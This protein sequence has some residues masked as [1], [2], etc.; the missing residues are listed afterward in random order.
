MACHACSYK[1]LVSQIRSIQRVVKGWNE[2]HS[3]EYIHAQV[4]H[5]LFLR[6][7]FESLIL[8]SAH[9]WICHHFLCICPRLELFNFHRF[10][11]CIFSVL[12]WKENIKPFCRMGIKVN[13]FQNQK[14]KIGYSG[15]WWH[16]FINIVTMWV[17]HQ[18]YLCSP[19]R[20]QNHFPYEWATIKHFTVVALLW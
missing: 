15:I 5:D 10:W 11:M 18:H 6:E 16:F 20:Q 3:M 9:N 1:Y 14:I 19:L 8:D 13:I 7:I 12:F 4:C 2:F 17:L